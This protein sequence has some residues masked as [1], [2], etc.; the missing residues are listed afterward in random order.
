MF[1]LSIADLKEA[2]RE[3]VD[4]LAKGVAYSVSSQVSLFEKTLAQMATDAEVVLAVSTANP[5]LIESAANKLQR[6]L[7]HTLKLRILLPD[8]KDVDETAIPHMGY[9]DLAMV[10]KTLAGTS[11]QS[12]IQGQ[13]ENRHFAITTAIKKDEKVI[14]VILASLEFSFIDAIL[15][16]APITDNLVEIKQGT[17]TLGASGDT[18]IKTDSSETLKI[19]G[20]NWQLHYWGASSQ[21]LSSI[22]MVMGVLI[23]ASLFACAALF[24]CYYQIIG[25]LKKDQS[26]ILQA[27]KDL[28]TGKELGNYTVKLSEM[29]VIISTLVQFK[30]ILNNKEGNGEEAEESND[31]TDSQMFNL[32][33]LSVADSPAPNLK[34]KL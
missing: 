34:K 26:S 24:F 25:L 14:G 23:V 32:D 20:I 31:I 3:S 15:A 21:T 5:L 11:P 22:S 13:G 29:K 2:K 17:V 30:R 6:F 10:Q 16:K 8:V 18:S 4:A 1:W 28:M 27:V 7:P 12:I 19:A 33:D 9:A